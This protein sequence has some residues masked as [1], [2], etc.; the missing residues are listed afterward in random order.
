MN[1][2]QCYNY[3]TLSENSEPQTRIKPSELRWEALTIE[4]LSYYGTEISEILWVGKK[5][6]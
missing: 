5:R 1:Q 6:S 2:K 3:I 4:Q